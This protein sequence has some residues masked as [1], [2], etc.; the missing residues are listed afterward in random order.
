M[1][2]L[3]MPI[4]RAGTWTTAETFV[5]LYR[6][7]TINLAGTDAYADYRVYNAVGI[8][9]GSG[10]FKNKRNFTMVGYAKVRIKTAKTTEYVVN[11]E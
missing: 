3:R 6:T 11:I 5:G 2:D 9:T 8:R 1:K 7:I 10:R 4:A